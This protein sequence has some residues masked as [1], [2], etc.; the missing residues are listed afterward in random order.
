MDPMATYVYWPMVERIAP[1]GRH[2]ANGRPMA[3]LTYLVLF[4]VRLFMLH[5]FSMHA[6]DYISMATPADSRCDKILELVFEFVFE[7]AGSKL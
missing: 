5:C 7:I 6:C 4:G 1:L 3:R 2:F